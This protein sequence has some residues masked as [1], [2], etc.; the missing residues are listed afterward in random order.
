MLVY[1]ACGNPVGCD[2]D[3][4]FVF[5]DYEP[6]IFKQIREQDGIS[7][8]DYERALEETR[9]EKFSEGASG[10]FLY[11]SGDERFIV[12]T[13][14]QE[15]CDVLLGMLPD[16]CEHIRQYPD[17][18]LTRFYG[19]HSLRMYGRVM[20]FVVMGNVFITH[21]KSIHERFDLKGSWVNRHRQPV[22]KGKQ[23]ECRYCNQKFKV[24]DKSEAGQ[25]PARPNRNHEPNNVSKDNDL[26][27]K[28]RLDRVTSLSVG[29]TIIADTN[30]LRDHG[31]MDYSLLLGIHREKYHLMESNEDGFVSGE[32]SSSVLTPSQ[33]ART[34][35]SGSASGGPMGAD[36]SHRSHGGTRI[37]AVSC[38]SKLGKQAT[39]D[40]AEEAN[41]ARL[42]PSIATGESP[43]SRE[44]P[45]PLPARNW[46]AG[47]S[48][49]DEPQS[50][51]TPKHQNSFQ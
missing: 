39:E 5:R 34:R 4:A 7:A 21:G 28:L 12:K 41:V 1:L 43:I 24:G 40:A 19:C 30:F 49:A 14:Q 51:R 48:Q 50:R 9:R 6:H 37:V 3:Q 47:A 36:G 29:D 22:E 16:Y 11:F 13:M 18:L 26:N 17:S 46:R 44:Q 27:F 2:D 32:N 45:I 15:E 31:I 38:E 8:R 25:C 33:L 42:S 20:F 35:G 23:M 10:A